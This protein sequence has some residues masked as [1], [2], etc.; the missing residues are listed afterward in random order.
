MNIITD[1]LPES[2][3]LENKIYPI[4]TDFKV[5]LKFYRIM[6]DKNKSPAERSAAAIVCCFDS[7]KCKSLPDTLEKT[8]KL[9]FD[10]YAGTAERDSDKKASVGKKVFDF[11]ED[12]EY[13]Y[14]A[15]F[16]EY[17][18]DLAKSEMHW[19][20]FLALFNNLSEN[21]RLG[22]IIAWRSVDLSKIEDSKRRDFYR[23]MKALY[24]LEGNGVDLT[25]KDIA[26]EISKAF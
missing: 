16:Q 24:K 22:R 17:G 14:A 6:S 21:T 3:E 1:A 26:T 12:A 20:R 9:L 5:W 13:I 11:N 2:V 19:Y 10:F 7:K 23:R 15:F 8:M 4:K 25:E 18:I